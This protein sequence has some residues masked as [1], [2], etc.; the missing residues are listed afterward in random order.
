MAG[1]GLM[2]ALLSRQT[3]KPMMRKS[4]RAPRNAPT[5]NAMGPRLTVASRQSPPGIT[6]LSTPTQI[7]IIVFGGRL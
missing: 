4:I 1:S 7:G 5:P 6:A 3:T 2:N